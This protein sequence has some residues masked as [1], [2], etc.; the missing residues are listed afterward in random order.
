MSFAF[1]VCTGPYTF[2]NSDTLYAMID[3]LKKLGHRVSG[4][5][6]YID[7]V[8]NVSKK[9]KVEKG[10]RDLPAKLQLLV[11][12]GIPIVACSACSDYRGIDNDNIA[13]GAQLGG[14][15]TLSDYIE[16]SDKIV[17]FSL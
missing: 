16:E 4:V 5:F 3:A 7:G 12:S 13:N 10:V 9:I 14:L 11:E 17:V 6:F 2:Q 1:L 8:I 15:M